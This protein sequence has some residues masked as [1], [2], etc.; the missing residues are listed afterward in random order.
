MP[1]DCGRLVEKDEHR[2]TIDDCRR[3]ELLRSIFLDKIDRIPSFD[4][5][6]SLFDILR[7]AVQPS[8]QNGQFNQKKTTFL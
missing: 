6:Y 2:M 7:F 4:I 1:A 5:R 3:V 8:C